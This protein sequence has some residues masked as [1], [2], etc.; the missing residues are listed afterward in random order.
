MW[1]GRLSEMGARK[2]LFWSQPPRRFGTLSWMEFGDAGLF[3][4]SVYD[5]C[6]LDLDF[7]MVG[8]G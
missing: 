5:N 3:V 2:R 4:G 1:R 6:L 8:E 7:E